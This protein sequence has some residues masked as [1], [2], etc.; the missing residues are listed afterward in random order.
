MSDYL[1]LSEVLRRARES[2]GETLEQVHQHTGIGQTVLQGLEAGDLQVVETVYLR[3]AVAH[4]ATYLGLEADAVVRQLESET[5][6]A[7][8]TPV[9]VRTTPSG[10]TPSVSASTALADLLRRLPLGRAIAIGV[11]AIVVL[12]LAVYL[13]SDTD[14]GGAGTSRTQSAP[15]APVVE[16]RPEP[17]PATPDTATASAATSVAVPA[18]ALDRVPPAGTDERPV[19]ATTAGGEA[20]GEPSSA[21]REPAPPTAVA[22]AANAQATAEASVPEPAPVEETAAVAIDGPGTADATDSLGAAVAIDSPGTADADVL[23]APSALA[24]PTTTGDTAAV[25]LDTSAAR[26][27]LQVDAIDSTW[28]QVQWDGTDGVEEI[29]PKGERRLWTAS[30]FFMV[31]AGRAHGVHVRFQGQLLGDGRLGDPTKVLRFRAA[32]DGVQLLG[33]D[34]EP[35]APAARILPESTESSSPGAG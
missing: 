33:P 25:T 20:P 5:G 15:S 13:F 9:V 4:Y 8:P 24:A 32:A 35:I 6:A 1:S 2:R 16:A 23:D 18:S 7:A 27:V 21:L 29:I 31:R 3:L 14:D 30:S 17:G 19:A 26:L 10:S 11:V 34:L 28:I 12:I 22:E